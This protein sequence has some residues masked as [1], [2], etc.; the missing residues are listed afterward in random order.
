MNKFLRKFSFF[1]ASI[2]TIT[3]ANSQQIQKFTSIPSGSEYQLIDVYST[4]RLNKILSGELDEFMHSSTMPT[5]FRGKFTSAKYPVRL[6]RVKYRSVVPELNNRPTIASGLVAVPDT[7]AN[8][9]P[10]VSYQHGT[11]FG[12]N[13]V[14]SN[15]DASS[16]TRIMI[17]QFAA[18]GYVVVAA[19]YFGRGVSDLP[20]SYLVKG[21]TQQAGSD[22]FFAALDMLGNLNIKTTHLFLSGWSQGGWV[23]M[24]T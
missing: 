8:A 14:P 11:V 22:M 10:V 7:G 9:M 3:V 12:K 2:L 15:P 5:A 16:E 18:Q 13:E 6:Y 21:S 24:Q 17:A 4:E 20:D 1:L 23:T 19:D